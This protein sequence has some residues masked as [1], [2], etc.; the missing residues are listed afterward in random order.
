MTGVTQLTLSNQSIAAVSPCGSL[1]ATVTA[2]GPRV[3]EV[4][5]ADL[6]TPVLA[7]NL[8][9]EFRTAAI[10]PDL[11]FLAVALRHKPLKLI[12]LGT[13]QVASELG[14]WKEVGDIDTVAFSADAKRLATA[15]DKIRIWDAATGEETAVVP[16]RYEDASLVFS[17]DG[18]T[19]FFGSRGVYAADATT[20][21]ITHTI[22]K[23]VSGQHIPGARL[24]LTPDGDTLISMSRNNDSFGR[25]YLLG[26]EDL[27]V[28]STRSQDVQMIAFSPSGRFSA[29]TGQS[30]GLLRLYEGACER[31]IHSIELPLESSHTVYVEALAFSE[32]D[33]LAAAYGDGRG[34]GLFTPKHFDAIVQETNRKADE[35][36]RTAR[37]E[38]TAQEERARKM[39]EAAA[40]AEAERRR[41]EELRLPTWKD[42]PDLGAVEEAFRKTDLSLT[43]YVLYGTTANAK[44]ATEGDRFDREDATEAGRAHQQDLQEKQ[45]RLTCGYQWPDLESDGTDVVTIEAD[46]PLS[47]RIASEKLMSPGTSKPARPQAEVFAS[48]YEHR[49]FALMKSGQLEPVASELLP[50]LK[51]RKAIVYAPALLNGGRILIRVAGDRELLKQIARGGTDHFLHLRISKLRVD[52]RSQAFYRLDAL[53]EQNWCT[54]HLGLEDWKLDET[55]PVYRPRNRSDDSPTTLL[56]DLEELELVRVTPEGKIVL[57]KWK[58]TEK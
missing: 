5:Q 58:A 8:S 46:L 24:Q 50:E 2:E 9:G 39:A 22:N 7:T 1:I 41:M 35:R 34:L 6:K 18:S 53:E 57:V 19:L 16:G 33:S 48:N 55:P 3:L 28:H 44:K 26:V 31:Q 43:D 47:V 20:G 11:Q 17:K 37:A 29:T 38:A 27:K 21:E 52:K 12:N 32:T 36:I 54:D 13:K 30:K 4:W 15:S 23:D 10:S 56:G 14:T 40:V 42:L 45:W 49:Y 25:A 51:E